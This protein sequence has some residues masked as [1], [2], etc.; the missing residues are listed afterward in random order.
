M[1]SSSSCFV[2]THPVS[3][4][5]QE[6]Q[7]EEIFVNKDAMQVSVEAG[8]WG[9]RVGWGEAGKRRSSARDSLRTH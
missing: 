6:M 1:S 8:G 4:A 5:L 2:R 3:I 9:G 7:T